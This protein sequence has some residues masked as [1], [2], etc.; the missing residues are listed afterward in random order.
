MGKGR[1][2]QWCKEREGPWAKVGA[3]GAG[4]IT[5]VSFFCGPLAELHKENVDKS[6]QFWLGAQGET[7]GQGPARDRGLVS[8]SHPRGETAAHRG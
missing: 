3:S 8:R 1:G 4:S 7:G 5:R 6:Q 2:G